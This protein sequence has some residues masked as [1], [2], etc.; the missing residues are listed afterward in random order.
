M[1]RPASASKGLLLGGN[2]V[3][4]LAQLLAALHSA[5]SIPF[6]SFLEEDKGW[7]AHDLE[8]LRQIPVVRNIDLCKDHSAVEL[9]GH[10]SQGWGHHVTGSTPASPEINSYRFATAQ[11][12]REIS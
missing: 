8:L 12:F 4:H 7:N 2:L 10:V 9:I 1:G 11:D 3:E 6:L 5:D